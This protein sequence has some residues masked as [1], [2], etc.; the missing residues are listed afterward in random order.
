M[1]NTFKLLAS[2][3][4]AAMLLASPTLQADS[5]YGYS[6]TGA[7]GVTATAR[8]NINVTVPTL[9]LLRVGPATGVSTLNFTATPSATDAPTGAAL[10]ALT[11][12][13]SNAA[14]NWNGTSAP[15]FTAPTGQT[16]SAYTWTNSA[17]GGRLGLVTAVNTPL[18]GITPAAITVQV[19][20]GG[21][22]AMPA[23]PATT[24]DA[25]SFGDFTR[26]TLH[27]ANWTYSVDPAALAA[28]SAGTYEQVTTYTA[29][30][31]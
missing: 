18:A 3:S 14:A 8:V 28:A 22:G 9:I 1:K 4:A 17:G 27:S 11:G 26:N 10:A 6:P 25:P 15:A 20:T 7:G 16:V 12:D 23:H 2:A 24:T 29:T 21:V 19:A 13:T 31:L 5:E 30:A